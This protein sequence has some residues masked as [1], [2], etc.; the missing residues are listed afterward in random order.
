MRRSRIL[1]VSMAFLLLLA[2]GALVAA[3][4][5]AQD[6]E[7]G[8]LSFPGAG[9]EARTV[10]LDGTDDASRFGQLDVLLR[11]ESGEA[12]TP[13]LDFVLTSSGR[14]VEVPDGEEDTT[15][16]SPTDPVR[17]SLVGDAPSISPF[18]A[19]R[20]S[21]TV[22]VAR[23]TRPAAAAGTLVAQAAPGEK[24]DVAT[25][26]VSAVLSPPWRWQGAVIEPATITISHVTRRPG[27]LPAEPDDAD[28]TVTVHG[29]SADT[30]ADA[31]PGVVFTSTTG[32]TARLTF[33]PVPNQ[34]PDPPATG[35][36][37]VEQISGAGKYEGSWLL[38]T[39]ASE[40]Q[41]LAVTV[42]ARDFLLWP[43]LTLL[44]GV[45]VAWA[46]LGWRATRAARRNC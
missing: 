14:I 42:N 31:N 38:D 9:T 20:L 25:L 2:T 36:L 44:A 46:A 23:G 45:L 1:S 35:I 40:P 30:L 33:D 27:F 34:N 6:E 16:P 37:N 5:A 4:A 39:E 11:N 21:F 12:V 7:G 28:R 15:P 18:E 17:I 3:P 29:V 32:R 13:C 24:V 10:L 43:L 41:K 19:E 22:R 8:A 26:P